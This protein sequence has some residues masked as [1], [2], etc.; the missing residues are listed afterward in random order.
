MTTIDWIKVAY[1]VSAIGQ[2]AFVLFYLTLP[3][4]RT[5]LGRA[6]FFKSAVLMILLDLGVASLQWGWLAN[7]QFFLFMYWLLALSIWGQFA[8]FVWSKY[9]KTDQDEA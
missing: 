8:A 4:W 5:Y 3:W 9:R 1:H 2:T 6:L 7:E